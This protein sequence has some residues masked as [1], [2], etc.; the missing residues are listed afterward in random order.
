MRRIA[1]AAFLLTA[2]D[3]TAERIVISPGITLDAPSA[4]EARRDTAATWLLERRIAGKIE[5]TMI[6][7]VE[8]RRNQAEAVRRL[9]EIDAEYEPEAEFRTHQGWPALER[10]IRL[11]LERPDHEDPH[12]IRPAADGNILTW[13][14]TTAVAAAASLVHLHTVLDPDADVELAD[15][16]LRIGRSLNVPAGPG[17]AVTL[18]PRPRPKEPRA[19]ASKATKR[20][21]ATGA[22]PKMVNGQGEIEAAISK[23]GKS[24]LTIATCV[25]SYSTDGGSTFRTVA[26]APGAALDFLG[27]CSVAWGPS[28]AFYRSALHTSSIALYRSGDLTLGFPYIGLAVE[29][30]ER[31]DQP[32]IAADRW[33]PSK[34]GKGDRVYVVWQE[35]PQW[36]ARIACSSNSGA[37]WGEP[38]DAYSGTVGYP[39]VAVGR[40]GMVYVVSRAGRN[41]NIA[42]FSDCD[43]GLVG[44]RGF[45]VAIT[46]SE[47]TCPMPG[48]DRCNN[49]NTLSSPTIAVDDRH[50]SN[51]YLGYAQTNGE[52]GQDILV[53]RS[54]DGGL[55]FHDAVALNGRVTAKRFMPWLGAWH[56]VVYAGWYDRRDATPAANDLTSYYMNSVSMVK[57]RL[58]PGTEVDLSRV[59]DPQ[60]AS[61]WRCGTRSADDA[62]SCSK[63]QSFAI[64]CGCP[65]YGDYNGLAVSGGTLVNLWAT[66][67]SPLTAVSSPSVEAWAVVTKLP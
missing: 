18:P 42:K 6:V 47:V 62:T 58:K 60:C 29:R 17:R 27:D 53:A 14:V 15:E 2:L 10:K 7:R 11:P 54:T 8:Q 63:P 35:A 40:D 45:P 19:Y 24:I 31:I 33:H 57:G 41:I 39:R 20:H 36:N 34:T 50:P 65:K 59:A 61:G 12:E 3:T 64:G 4:W 51:V 38:A 66:V 25:M 49:G 23:N 46:I 52:G 55:T 16:A 28:G 67:T 5:A 37:T 32:H 43:A 22:A 9:A 44:Q 26:P 30:T 56:G 48:L 1:I 13:R 21:A